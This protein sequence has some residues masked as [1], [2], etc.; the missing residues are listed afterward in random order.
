MRDG[1][2]RRARD[3][4]ADGRA[5]PRCGA[6]V[7]RRRAA[8]ARSGRPRSQRAVRRDGRRSGAR[9]SAG[10]PTRGRWRED[11]PALGD[12]PEADDLRPH[13]RARGRAR[14]RRCPSRWAASGTGTTATPGC[15]TRR[16]RCT[17]CCGSGFDDEAAQF[18]A[19]AAATGSASGVGSDSGPLNIMYRIDGSSDLKE[20]I[21]RPLARLPRFGAGAHRQRRRRAAAARHLR[22]GAGQ[23]LRRRPRRPAA[24]PPGV[25]GDQPGAGLAGRATGTSPRRASGRPAAGGSR[26]PTA[27]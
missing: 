27:G 5:E 23:H 3:A 18:G 24:R 12:H 7:G 8:R 15:A 4:R 11:D 20:D 13:R 6:R 10:R 21:A 25:D 26:S 16:S 2:R 1:R 9:G 17:R 14:P 19:L 22:R